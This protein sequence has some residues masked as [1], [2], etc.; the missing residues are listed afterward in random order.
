M[1]KS[2][3]TFLDDVWYYL[4]DGSSKVRVRIAERDSY[5]DNF[6]TFERISDGHIFSIIG[7]LPNLINEKTKEEFH[8]NRYLI[9]R[10]DDN[11]AW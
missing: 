1:A 11:G 8:D 2:K 10:F 3:Q 6:Y 4:E 5:V 7:E 9:G